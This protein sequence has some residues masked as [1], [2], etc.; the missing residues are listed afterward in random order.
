M[1]STDLSATFLRAGLPID[2]ILGTDILRRFI[3]KI[4]FSSGLVEFESKAPLP[5]DAAVIKLEPVDDMYYVPLT[6]QGTPTRLLLDTGANST[7][8]SSH[9]WSRITAHWQP[10]S[11]LN[12][13]RSTG[14]TEDAQFALV[15]TISMSGASSR[16]VPLRIQPQTAQ[17]LFG[18]ADFDGLLGSDILQQF[19]VT[20]DLTNNNMYLS[21]KP[22][23]RVDQYLFTTIGIQFAKDLDGYFAIMAVWDPSP[24]QAAGLKIGDL[25]LSVNQHDARQMSLDDLSREVHGNSGTEVHLLIESAG[26]RYTVTVPIRCLLCPSPQTTATR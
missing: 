12:G 10:L 26:R 14:S 24:A 19:N 13:V 5:V 8:I 4:D 2:G 3:V 7:S 20:L 17:G 9:A 15:P 6:L 11:V 16:D 25:I 1:L 22:N 18:E 21:H 23:S